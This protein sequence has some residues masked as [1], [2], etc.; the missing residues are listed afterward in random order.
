MAASLS[1]DDMSA[2]DPIFEVEPLI[3]AALHLTAGQPIGRSCGAEPW[4][5]LCVF[6]LAKGGEDDGR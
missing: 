4:A 3:L 6:A 1:R 5:M 2:F